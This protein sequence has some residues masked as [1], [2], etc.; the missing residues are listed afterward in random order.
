MANVGDRSR[1]LAVVPAA[2]RSRRM[3][4]PKQLVEIHG[5]PMLDVMLEVL[6]PTTL[7]G[8][9]VVTYREIRER[10]E[11]AWGDRVL[12]VANDDPDSAMIDSIRLGLRA[13]ADREQAGEGDGFLVCPADH[14]ELSAEDVHR[15]LECFRAAPHR[16]VV[17]IRRGRRGHPLIF[18][19]KYADFVHSPACDEGLNA[20]P[21][22]HAE[23]VFEVPCASPGV[24]NDVDTPAD[25]G[26]QSHPAG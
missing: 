16:I 19:A 7:D 21:R 25:L 4:T 22:E 13:W 17:A 23:Q 20:L 1:V 9:A 5:R 26:P 11:P 2:G 24:L 14:P 18:P 6:A 3:G 12:F 8:I 15:C 10:F